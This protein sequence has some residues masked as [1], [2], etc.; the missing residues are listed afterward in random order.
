[1]CAYITT[2]WVDHG[3]TPNLSLVVGGAGTDPSAIPDE[4]RHLG[5]L[6]GGAY[7]YTYLQVY[8]YEYVLS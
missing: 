6:F 3:L 2:C 1:M 8:L 7:I 5:D 4:V